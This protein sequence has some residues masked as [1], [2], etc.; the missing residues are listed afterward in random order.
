MPSMKKN[1]KRK[2]SG[3]ERQAGIIAAAAALF[4]RRGFTGAT[5]KAIA[6][7]AGCSEALVFKY[8]P[9]KRALYAAILAEK[10][11]LGEMMVAVEDAAKKKDDRLVFTTLARHRIR[12]NADPTLLRLLLFSALE[13]H[14]L[15]KMFFKNQHRVFYDYLAAYIEQ[16]TRDG[17]FRRVD[18]LLGARSFMGLIAHHRLLHELFGVALHRSQEECIES[19]VSLFLNGIQTNGGKTSA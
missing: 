13:G 11:P 9:T 6:R 15:S 17:A 10:V 14:E 4:A 7:T 16:R 1:G 19:Y 12:R 5:T 18:P 3:Q 8:F 2:A